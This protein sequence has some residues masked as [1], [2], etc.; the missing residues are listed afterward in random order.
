MAARYALAARDAPSRRAWT[1]PAQETWKASR[2]S[3]ND[4]ARKKLGPRVVPGESDKAK[5]T[6]QRKK[7]TPDVGDFDGHTA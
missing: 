5:M 6:P 7:K 2:T 4:Q 1:G 3:E